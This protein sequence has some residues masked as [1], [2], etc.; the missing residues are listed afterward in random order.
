MPSF[1]A[2]IGK[3]VY[4]IDTPHSYKGQTRCDIKCGFA[5]NMQDFVFCF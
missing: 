2:M 3:L 4:G 5:F 1:S